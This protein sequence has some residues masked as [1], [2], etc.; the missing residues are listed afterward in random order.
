MAEEYN[1]CEKCPYSGDRCLYDYLIGIVEG[2]KP[3]ETGK[4]CF[5][6][7]I[8]DCIFNAD[9]SQPARQSA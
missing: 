2:N 1:R 3:A 9:S 8:I 4:R 5:N 7:N 6:P